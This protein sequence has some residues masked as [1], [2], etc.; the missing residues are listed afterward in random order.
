MS[1]PTTPLSSD[2]GAMP[3]IASNLPAV[4]MQTVV[5]AGVL[6]TALALALGALDIPSNAGYG[7]VGPNFLPW[8]VAAVLGL[9]GC[10]LLWEARTGGFHAMEEPNGA[11]RAD[12]PAWVWVSTGLLLNAALITTVGFILSC[13]LC[14][15]LA[16]QGLRRAAGQNA[17]TAR[18]WAVD[19]L[20]GVLISAPVYW[21]FT[22]FL[23]INL[24]G[25]TQTGWL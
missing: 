13:T 11:A 10:V 15:V 16:V 20:T 17:G 9:C 8:L 21:T 3:G 24:P 4:R 5:G 23:A 25:L 1:D 2:P 18:T 12:K 6:L 19:G 22:Q 14:Y 7:G